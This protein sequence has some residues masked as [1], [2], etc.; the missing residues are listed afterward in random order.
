MK[1][2]VLLDSP[3][4]CKN[5]RHTFVVEKTELNG[6]LLLHEP[7]FRLHH[8]DRLTHEQKKPYYYVTEET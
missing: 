1:I 3:A 6:I 2:L 7:A 5:I 4:I 8:L